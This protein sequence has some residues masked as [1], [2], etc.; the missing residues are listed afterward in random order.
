MSIVEIIELVVLCVVVLVL[1]VYYSIQAIKNH[2][3]KEILNTMNEAIK[4]AELNIKDGPSKKKYVLD[5]LEKKCNELSIPFSLIRKLVSKLIDKTIAD[6][7]V[8]AKK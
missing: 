3:I 4:Y 8:I 6:Y 1:V 7:N 2:W 5:E